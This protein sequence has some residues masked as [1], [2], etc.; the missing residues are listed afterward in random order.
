MKSIK[1]LNEE[2][3]KAE[4]E[5]KELREEFDRNGSWNT[6]ISAQK[7]IELINKIACLKKLKEVLEN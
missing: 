2:I 5:L 7:H 6:Y 3:A 1:V 4:Q